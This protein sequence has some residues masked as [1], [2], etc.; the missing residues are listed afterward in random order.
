VQ[1]KKNIIYF[2]TNAFNKHI[3]TTFLPNNEQNEIRIR[4]LLREIK[5]QLYNQNARSYNTSLFLEVLIIL[6]SIDGAQPI[7]LC[8]FFSFLF[9]SF[10]KKI[11]HSFIKCDTIYVI[12]LT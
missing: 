11:Q 6:E 2:N 9:F 3:H 12:I 1:E 5:L 4:M 8:L 10:F 7:L